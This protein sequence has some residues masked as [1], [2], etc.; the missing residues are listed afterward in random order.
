MDAAGLG[1]AKKT[2]GRMLTRPFY[3]VE[4]LAPTTPVI[5]GLRGYAVEIPDHHIGAKHRG[6]PIEQPAGTSG[7][8]KPSRDRS[9]GR[10]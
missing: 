7:S 5:Q 4:R 6:G 2:N 8:G 1:D 9:R 10:N 3:Q